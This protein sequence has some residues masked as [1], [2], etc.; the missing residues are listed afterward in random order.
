M[1]LKKNQQ[2]YR[3]PPHERIIGA[4][5][6]GSSKDGLSEELYYNLQSSGIKGR[7]R[8]F[9]VTGKWIYFSPVPNK[10]YVVRVRYY[11]PLA[12]I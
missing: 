2:R 6:L 9:C 11:L 12:E 3:L 10:R 8:S 7:P 5:I 4:R 1:I